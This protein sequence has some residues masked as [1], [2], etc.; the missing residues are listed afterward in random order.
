MSELKKKI[1]KDTRIGRREILE[2]THLF[3]ICYKTTNY[4]DLKHIKEL[5]HVPG[6]AEEH[7]D[8]VMYLVT[9]FSHVFNKYEN[10]MLQEL[11]TLNNRN[12]IISNET[13]PPRLMSMCLEEKVMI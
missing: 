3:V 8:M 2:G 12:A 10:R 5:N 1:H 6:T 4:L 11:D 13:V 9:K 7:K